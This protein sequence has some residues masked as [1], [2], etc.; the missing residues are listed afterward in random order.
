METTKRSANGMGDCDGNSEGGDS[1]NG[2]KDL[3]NGELTRMGQMRS[4][5]CTG[6]VREKQ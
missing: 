5:T 6:H 4:Q 2:R 3:W 1:S